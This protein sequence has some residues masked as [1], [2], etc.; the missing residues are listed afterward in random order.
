M[1]WM[2]L[3]ETKLN[4]L[5]GQI[6]PSRAAKCLTHILQVHA[7]VQ[8]MCASLIKNHTVLIGTVTGP[9]SQLDYLVWHGS[10]PEA[11]NLRLIE[12]RSRIQI[13]RSNRLR[14]WCASKARLSKRMCCEFQPGVIQIWKHSPPIL[15]RWTP[16]RWRQAIVKSWLHDMCSCL[17]ER[18]LWWRPMRFWFPMQMV[19][20]LLLKELRRMIGIGL[21]HKCA[22][23]QTDIWAFEEALLVLQS[24]TLCSRGRKLVHLQ[25]LYSINSYV[26]GHT[27]AQL[28]WH[29]D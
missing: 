19:S 3:V 29:N 21:V 14:R 24:S 4:Y 26:N 13:V 20:G 10:I 28:P 5:D 27:F 6:C 25:I 2:S 23:I 15:M 9:R 8:T 11:S 22:Q 18:S 12:T 1:G 7:L 16:V 17:W